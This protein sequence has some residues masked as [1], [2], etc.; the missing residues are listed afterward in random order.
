MAGTTF[1]ASEAVGI[2]AA[3]AIIDFANG[4]MPQFTI[5]PEVFKK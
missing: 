2:G 3:Q 1:E 5:N 4:K